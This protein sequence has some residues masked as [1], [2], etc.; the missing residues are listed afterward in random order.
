ME[1]TKKEFDKKIGQRIRDLREYQHFTREN[2]AE[3]A[4]TSV[5]FV[6][7]IECGRK[8]MTTFTLRKLAEALH[9]STDYIIYGTQTETKDSQITLLLETMNDNH[10]EI[11]E[12]ILQLY[13]LAIN[14]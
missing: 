12:R 4:D 6:A 8:G 3:Y 5:Q 1:M 7:D 11:A 14:Q 10:R 9:V 2:L 13:I